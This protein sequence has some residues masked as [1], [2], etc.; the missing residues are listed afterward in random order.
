MPELTLTPP[1]AG[2]YLQ[3]HGLIN[4]TDAVQVIYSRE[5]RTASWSLEAVPSHA[6]LYLQLHDLFYGTDA[7]QVI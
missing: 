1:Y 2:L 3:L 6:G 4:G 7:V 5:G